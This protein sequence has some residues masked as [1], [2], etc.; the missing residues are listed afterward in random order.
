M[1]TKLSNTPMHIENRI[2]TVRGVQVMVDYHLSELYDVETKRI[3]EQVKR[4]SKRFPEAFMFQVSGEEWKF[5]QSQIATTEKQF[6]LQSQIATTKRRTNPYVF[7]EQGVAMLSAV[8]NSDTA[9]NASIEIMNAF[10]KMR[11]ILLENTLISHRL[12]KI[13]FKQLETEQKIERVFKALESK[14]TIPAQGV[15]FNE[16]VFDAYELASKIIRSATKSIVLI[17]NYIDENTLTLLS[18]KD[19]KVKALLLT[20]NIAKQ[21]ILDVQKANEQY[22]NFKLK[23][24]DKSHDRFLI[25][26]ENEVYH[27]GAS[28]KDL[29]KK[30]FAFSKMDKKSVDTI[31]NSIQELL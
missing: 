16:S 8:L 22:G 10:V 31:L 3:N 6:N 28:L 19:K 14:N 25:I 13:E 7:T 24:F 18:K 4:N 15:F 27:I 9:I 1:N 21:T 12:D 17:D 20:K 5:L 30:W 2:Y 26:D 29:G 23:T 11:Q